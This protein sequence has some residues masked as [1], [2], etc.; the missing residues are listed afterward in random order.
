MRKGIYIFCISLIVISSFLVT[1]CDPISLKTTIDALVLGWTRAVT[2][3]SPENEVGIA[4]KTPLLDWEDAGGA[5]G[6]QVQISETESFDGVI[7]IEIDEAVSQYEIPNELTIC[8]TRYWRVRAV[9]NGIVSDVWSEAWSFR[10]VV[11]EVPKLIGQLEISTQPMGMCI[12]NNFAYVSHS[13][14]VKQ[15]T[16]I[17]ISDPAMPEQ[18]KQFDYGAGFFPEITED[19]LYCL[20]RHVSPDYEIVHKVDV[21]DPANPVSLGSINLIYDHDSSGATP[22]LEYYANDYLPPIGGA[23]LLIPVRDTSSI[24]FG[25]MSVD[26]SNPSSPVITGMEYTTPDEALMIMK[27][28]TAALVTVENVGVHSFSLIGGGQTDSLVLDDELDSGMIDIEGD[29]A[30]ISNIS[31]PLSIIDISD[32]YSLSLVQSYPPGSGNYFPKVS[33]DFLFLGL[34]PSEEFIVLDVADPASPVLLSE[35]NAGHICEVIGN[36]A[37]GV[38]WTAGKFNVYDLLPEDE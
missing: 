15:L 12:K 5:T 26:F 9:N 6:Y 21:S 32:P 10:I 25:V 13:S 7:P 8:D 1:S 4:E 22:D 29:L 17:D 33:G 16:I 20:E 11:S 18:H 30:Y 23:D 27:A 28:G 35:G 19:Y 14:G 2:L 38:E 36:Y 31:G 34:T 24:D 3:T 37:Y